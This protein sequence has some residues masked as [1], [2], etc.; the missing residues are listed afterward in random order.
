MA[1]RIPV[2]KVIQILREVELLQSEGS[3]VGE[4]CRKLGDSGASGAVAQGVQH[5]RAR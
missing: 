1:K 2:E 5:S 4:A 3:T